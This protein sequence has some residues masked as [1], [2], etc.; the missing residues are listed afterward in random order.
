MIETDRIVNT[1]SVELGIDGGDGL[2]LATKP[3]RQ[4]GWDKGARVACSTRVLQ[5]GGRKYSGGIRVISEEGYVGRC[6]G[7]CCVI[8]GGS[9]EVN[10]LKPEVKSQVR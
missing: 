3:T 8:E 1:L 4:V 7:V 10:E 5:D 6:Y 9:G 2:V